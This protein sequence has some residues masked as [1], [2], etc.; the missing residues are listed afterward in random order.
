MQF[1]EG[2]G[3]HSKEK[4]GHLIGRRNRALTSTTVLSMCVVLGLAALLAHRGSGAG[5]LIEYV[6][7]Q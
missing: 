5:G 1:T 3:R 6:S 2:G 4:G 7:L